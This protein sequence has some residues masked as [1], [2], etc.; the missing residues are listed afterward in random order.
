M[1]ND[2]KTTVLEI[3]VNPDYSKAATLTPKGR[4]PYKILFDTEIQ[5]KTCICR[6]CII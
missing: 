5:S 2:F 4:I 3:S 6:L 1:V